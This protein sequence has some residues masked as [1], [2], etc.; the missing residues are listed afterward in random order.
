MQETFTEQEE[1][2]HHRHRR[3][4]ALRPLR[5]SPR[6]LPQSQIQNS[7]RRQER[8]REARGG[9]EKE[10][11]KVQKRERKITEYDY[12]GVVIRS[13]ELCGTSQVNPREATATGGKG[14]LRTAEETPVWGWGWSAD[15]IGT[16]CRG[17]GALALAR[18]SLLPSVRPSPSLS[19]KESRTTGR[20]IPFQR[21][22]RP[23]RGNGV[24][25]EL[26]HLFRGNRMREGSWLAL[27]PDRTDD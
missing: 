4:A 2:T 3:A 15:G 5:R 11:R 26:S 17:A 24:K 8:G 19:P 16:G 20:G 1:E 18:S 27:L 9:R 6:G 10:R 23:F 14:A 7:P 13:V 22:T 12:W 25:G 21:E